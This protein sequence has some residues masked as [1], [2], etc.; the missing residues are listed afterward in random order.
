MTLA[1]TYWTSPSQTHLCVEVRHPAPREDVLSLV[2]AIN[3]TLQQ[4]PHPVSLTVDVS[5]VKQVPPDALGDLRYLLQARADNLEHV[6]LLGA[7]HDL[8]SLL[9]LFRRLNATFDDLVTVVRPS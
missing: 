9:A 3:T 5:P 4:R 6:Y 8:Y 7:N 2:Q 1:T